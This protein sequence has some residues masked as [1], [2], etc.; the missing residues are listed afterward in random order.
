[1]TVTDSAT[2]LDGDLTSLSGVNVT[3]TAAVT[4]AT[5]Q[6]I[7]LTNGSLTATAGTYPLSLTDIDGTAIHVSGGANVGLLDVT[8]CQRVEL[9]RGRRNHAHS[10][11][12]RQLVTPTPTALRHHLL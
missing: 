7:R 3:W 4:L 12:P 8:G 9:L 11:I 6:W 10:A 2:V 5:T 1:M